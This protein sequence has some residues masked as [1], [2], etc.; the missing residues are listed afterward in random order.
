MRDHQAVG[1]AAQVD[2]EHEQFVTLR[3]E[4]ESIDEYLAIEVV[5]FGPRLTRRQG[6][7][8]ETLDVIV[9]SMILQPL[10]E[11]SIKHG[12]AR[13][14]GAGRI[15]IRSLA[16]ARHAPS[17]KSRTMAWACPR[18]GCRSPMTSGIGLSNVQRTAAGASTAPTDRLALTGEPGKGACARLEIPS[19]IAAGASDG[20]TPATR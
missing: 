17:S 19:S 6:H 5:R 10:V 18:S 16:R 7:R 13:K 11:N 4:L 20:V 8:A 15:I 9:P 2:A 14:V 3:E 12:L 1:A